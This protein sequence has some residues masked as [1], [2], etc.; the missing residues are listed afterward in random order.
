MIIIILEEYLTINLHSDKIILHYKIWKLNDSLKLFKEKMLK[1]IY[2]Y[3]CYLNIC[4]VKDVK[5][6][7]K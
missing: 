6:I 5:Y 1:E 2:K 4:L 7:W 3:A